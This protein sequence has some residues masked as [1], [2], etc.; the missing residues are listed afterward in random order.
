L[1]VFSFLIPKEWTKVPGIT[2][3]GLFCDSHIILEADSKHLDSS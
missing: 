3:N 2:G 1:S